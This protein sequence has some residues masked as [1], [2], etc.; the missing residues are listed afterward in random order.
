MMIRKYIATLKAPVY[1]H[2]EKGH[3]LRHKVR[4]VPKKGA[5]RDFAIS[6]MRLHFSFPFALYNFKQVFSISLSVVNPYL[7]FASLIYFITYFL[8]SN[9]YLHMDKINDIDINHFLIEIE[10]RVHQN[11]TR[12]CDSANVNVQYRFEDVF[13]DSGPDIFKKMKELC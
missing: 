13:D 5:K 8:F 9:I 12:M 4:T 2:P 11:L 3:C 10:L 7:F 6:H 1:S